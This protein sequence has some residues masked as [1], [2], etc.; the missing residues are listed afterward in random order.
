[1]DNAAAN[2]LYLRYSS[3]S[4]KLCL[5]YI[6]LAKAPAV[7]G[8]PLLGDR[9]GGRCNLDN[10]GHRPPA[11]LSFR[12]VANI[13]SGISMN[14]GKTHRLPRCPNYT[15]RRIGRPVGAGH[16]PPGPAPVRSIAN[17]ISEIAMDNEGKTHRPPRCP[18]YPLRRIF[19][20]VGEGSRPPAF[21]FQPDLSQT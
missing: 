21:F 14:K 7:D 11:L 5:R 1:M 6:E 15:F 2:A 19:H 16:G 9:Y 10:A 12:S 4:P 13:I 17:M 18:N 20:P 8:A 3:K